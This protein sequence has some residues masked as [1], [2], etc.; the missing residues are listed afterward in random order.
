V[1]PRYAYLLQQLPQI[2]QADIGQLFARRLQEKL[3]T[4]SYPHVLKSD[5]KSTGRKNFFVSHGLQHPQNAGFERQCNW[6]RWTRDY[7]RISG[8]SPACINNQSREQQGVR[9]RHVTHLP[10]LVPAPSCP[11]Q[12]R[13]CPHLHRV[14]KSIKFYIYLKWSWGSSAEF[15]CF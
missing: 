11:K 6:R 14:S 15:H 7:C 9:Q 13:K 2:R 1:Y 12:T 8:R 10:R 4:R 5:C 3:P